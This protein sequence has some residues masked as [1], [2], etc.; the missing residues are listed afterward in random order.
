MNYAD[1]L[2]IAPYLSPIEKM[3]AIMAAACHDLDHPGVNQS[4]LIASSHHLAPLY[5]VSDVYMFV[6]LNLF[7]LY[8]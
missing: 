6:V 8:F 7:I 5:D 4:F 1:H 2:Q 3:A